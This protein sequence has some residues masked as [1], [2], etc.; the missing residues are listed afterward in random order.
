[1]T[2]FVAIQLQNTVQQ[3]QQKQKTLQKPATITAPAQ[4]QQVKAVPPVAGKTEKP[5]PMKKQRFDAYSILQTS[6]SASAGTM[7]TGVQAKNSQGV[8]K[9]V[10]KTQGNPVQVSTGKLATS[11]A[12]PFKSRASTLTSQHD[13]LTASQSL[14]ASMS[15]VSA[16]YKPTQEMMTSQSHDPSAQAMMRSS[17]GMMSSVSV[18][19]YQA[20]TGT[21]AYDMGS[22]QQFQNVPP[23][24]VMSSQAYPGNMAP[25]TISNVPFTTGQGH[26]RNF[27]TSVQQSVPGTF[28]PPPPGGWNQYYGIPQ[29]VPPPLPPLPKE[30]YP[31]PPPPPE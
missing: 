21:S 19:G 12:A 11:V 31:K 26:A 3:Q 29:P 4:Q 15:S 9:P 14:A 22:Y 30:E 5:K 7:S 17:Q 24:Y 16:M 28:V 18:A 6:A 2:I 8:K 23:G 1:M 20:Q 10:Q 25:S 13:M 27:A